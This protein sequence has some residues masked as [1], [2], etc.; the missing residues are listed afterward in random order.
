MKG[1]IYFV[2]GHEESERQARE[3]FQSFDRHGW[4]VHLRAG[5]TKRT[6]N[7]ILST[8]ALLLKVVDCMTSKEKTETNIIQRL[9]VL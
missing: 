2:E 6:V 9:A 4:D 1:F 8:V 3:S 7:Q 5:I